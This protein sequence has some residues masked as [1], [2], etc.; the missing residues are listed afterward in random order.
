L[1]QARRVVIPLVAPFML[2]DPVRRKRV[3]QF[4][5]QL[6]IR[7][8]DS[9]IVH[10]PRSREGLGKTPAAGSRAP[11]A[12]L[13]NTTLF[14]QMRGTGFHLLCFSKQGREAAKLGMEELLTPLLIHRVASEV[15]SALVD[16]EGEAFQRYGVSDSALYLVRPDGYIA[17]RAAGEDPSPIREYLQRLGGPAATAAP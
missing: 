12:R 17:T 5:S 6:G 13:G 4:I 14:E 15:S 10:E 7:Y 16:S 8:A 2:K 9:P 1:A 11:D 3:F